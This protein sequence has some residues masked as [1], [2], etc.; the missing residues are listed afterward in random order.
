[1]KKPPQHT[2]ARLFFGVLIWGAFSI[3]YAHAG[4]IQSQLLNDVRYDLD[5]P[6]SYGY[7]LQPLGY[8]SGNFSGVQLWVSFINT[9][10]DSQVVL[11][12]YPSEAEFIENGNWGT[13]TQVSMSS[14]DP[15]TDPSGF[16]VY[17][18][19][20]YTLDPTKF[21][22]IEFSVVTDPGPAS[23]YILGTGSG[24]FGLPLLHG[25]PD[26]ATSTEQSMY[27]QVFDSAGPT[28]YFTPDPTYSGL[29]TS[30]VATMCDNS[31]AT[32][33]GFLDSVGASISNG[34]CRVGAFLFVPSGSVLSQYASFPD[35]LGNKVPFSYYYDL[36]TAFSSSSA[37]STGNFTAMSVDLRGTGVG[38]TSSWGN[39]LPSSFSYLSST[40]IMT[41]VS[42]TMYALLFFMMRSAIWIAVLFHVYR[43]L[44]P[45]HVTHV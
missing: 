10:F 23:K 28:Q 29:A 36:E 6:G 8:L 31:F 5:Y 22:V 34:L 21:Y 16:A 45:H 7:F 9:V 30:S 40:T 2:L 39:V 12:E 35:T 25:Y 24:F 11:R 41:Y 44:V 32:T 15:L 38:S 33:S 19:S 43:R 27:F 37:S 14:G 13:N 3:P 1:M 4:T 20:N 18:M 17:D 42:P 26:Q